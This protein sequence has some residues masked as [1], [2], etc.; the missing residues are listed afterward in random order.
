MMKKTLLSIM[1][2]A[3]L[4]SSTVAHSKDVVIPVEA[5]VLPVLGFVDATTLSPIT[6]V[7]LEKHPALPNQHVIKMPAIL[8]TN[9]GDKRA[10]ITM[11]NPLR[12]VNSDGDELT[13]KMV[14]FAREELSTRATLFNSVEVNQA[15]DLNIIVE[16]PPAAKTGSYTG[17][18]ELILE[19][20]A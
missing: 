3:V 18:L 2:M 10:T 4:A 16:E 11:K 8:H 12:L 7:K 20:R 14:E 1:A 5:E 9:D 15:Q 6:L 19:S 13:T 17:S